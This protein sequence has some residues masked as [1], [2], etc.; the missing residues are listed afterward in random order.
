MLS[1][2]NKFRNNRIVLEYY[3][4]ELV[5]RLKIYE[6][7]GKYSQTN[8]SMLTLNVTEGQRGIF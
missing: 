1:L 4:Q 7:S 3:K 5:L 6:R 2:E 8:Q